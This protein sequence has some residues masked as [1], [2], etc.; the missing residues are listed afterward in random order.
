MRNMPLSCLLLLCLLYST[1]KLQTGT[2]LTREDGLALRVMG[3]QEAHPLHGSC[4]SRP[5]NFCILED[6]YA[7][8]EVVD[9]Q[10][11]LLKVMDTADQVME[12]GGMGSEQGTLVGLACKQFSLWQLHLKVLRWQVQ[13]QVLLCP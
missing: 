4:Y 6:T 2:L 13:G 10:P 8:E 11:V 9:Q 12:N 3:V 5:E 1:K 7:S